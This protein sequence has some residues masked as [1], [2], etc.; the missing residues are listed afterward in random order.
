LEFRKVVNEGQVN[1]GIRSTGAASQAGK[2]LQRSLLHI[3][4]SDGEGLSASIGT[5]QAE[6]LVPGS[7][8]L[9]DNVGTHKSGGPGNKNTHGNLSFIDS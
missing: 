5:R 2:I 3:G 1:D 7:N 4:S 9:L 8:Q 6:H